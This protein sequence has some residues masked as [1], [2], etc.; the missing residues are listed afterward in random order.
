MKER[1]I[2]AR[3][4]TQSY[5]RIMQCEDSSNAGALVQEQMADYSLNRLLYDS[6]DIPIPMRKSGL[7]GAF[8]QMLHSFLCSSIYNGVKF[9]IF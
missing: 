3:Y 6:T 1:K 2:W 9:V 4:N 8:P 5:T 7:S